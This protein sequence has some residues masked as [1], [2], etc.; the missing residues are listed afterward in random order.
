MRVW[1][2]PAAELE[3]S[4][5]VAWYSRYAPEIVDRLEAELEELVQRMTVAPLE[6]P[7]KYRS[8][9]QALF[10]SLPYRLFFTISRRRIE[11]LAVRHQSRDPRQ[12]P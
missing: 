11:V 7:V 4:E 1:F 12:W 2:R 10:A 3:L 9:R 6:F 8:V 5:I